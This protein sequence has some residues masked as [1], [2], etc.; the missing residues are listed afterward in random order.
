MELLME[1]LSTLSTLGLLNAVICLGICIR[2]MFYQRNGAKYS[3]FYSVVA[4]ALTVSSGA[5]SI[6]ILSKQYISVEVWE[7][8]INAALLIAV[9]AA[10]GNVASVMKSQYIQRNS[11]SKAN[12]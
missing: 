10:K 12:Y 3:P 1:Y 11:D 7:V 8:I 6:S 2:L 4:Y 5:A 9:F